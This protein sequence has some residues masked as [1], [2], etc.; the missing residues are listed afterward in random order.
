MQHEP[1]WLHVTKHPT[2]DVPKM[3][4]SFEGFEIDA[5][6]SILFFFSCAADLVCGMRQSEQTMY[7]HSFGYADVKLFRTPHDIYRRLKRLKHSLSQI[8]ITT[9]RSIPN[10]VRFEYVN[11]CDLSGNSVFLSLSSSIRLLS[12]VNNFQ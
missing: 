4:R 6:I 10:D 12:E 7:P 8:I 3:L 1:K 5:T 9:L 11:C 2:I